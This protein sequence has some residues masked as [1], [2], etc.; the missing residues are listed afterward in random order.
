MSDPPTLQTE[1]FA[2]FPNPPPTELA[3][4]L[5][6]GGYKWTAADQAGEIL[7]RSADPDR[8]GEQ[9][10]PW[11]GSLVVVDDRAEDAWRFCR[12]LRKRDVP[13]E[14]TL[15]LV[16]G[17]RLDDLSTRDD[18]FDDFII[19]P[20]LPQELEARLQHLQWRAGRGVR[21]ELIVYGP[22][23][24][25]VETYQAML[26]DRPLDLTYMEYELLRFLAASPGQ[27]FTREVLL[28]RVWGYEYYGGART[29]DVHIRR[30]RAKMGEEHSSL[31]STVRG[32]GYKL[33]QSRWQNG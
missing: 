26:E 21:P 12:E 30:L 3:R 8:A 24:L 11:A 17:S 10:S 31:I 4:F 18:L 16:S 23:S 32:V 20:F 14:P 2:V 29:V 15:I 5:D 33:G 1:S 19:M 6:I 13:V 27:V 28:N 7:D 22:L 25:N 9:R